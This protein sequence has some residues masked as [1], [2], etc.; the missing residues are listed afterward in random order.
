MIEWRHTIVLALCTEMPELLY[1]I[2]FLLSGG[3]NWL[4]RERN[5]INYKVFV[6]VG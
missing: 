2:S 4:E 5:I 6:V 3:I 1:S